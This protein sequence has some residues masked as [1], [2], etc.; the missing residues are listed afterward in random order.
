MWIY[1]VQT[2]EFL[3]TN[4]YKVGKTVCMKNRLNSYPVNTE[5]LLCLDFSHYP[6]AEREIIKIFR[7]TF[8]KPHCRR[9]YFCGDPYIM[10]MIICDLHAKTKIE[11]SIVH[12]MEWLKFLPHATIQKICKANKIKANN[13]DLIEKLVQHMNGSLAQE[14][15]CKSESDVKTTDLFEHTSINFRKALFKAFGIDPAKF[16]N[17]LAELDKHA[18]LRCHEY[19]LILP[20]TDI[21]NYCDKVGL[22]KLSVEEF[23]G[24]IK[25]FGYGFLK[26]FSLK[27]VQRITG[28]KL[29]KKAI[30]AGL[31]VEQ[32]TSEESESPNILDQIQ[33]EMLKYIQPVTK[34]DPLDIFKPLDPVPINTVETKKQDLIQF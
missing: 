13:K 6:V 11:S 32:K 33:P 16:N 22:K 15:Y 9:E 24:F 4:I 3:S 31:G 28:K 25:M 8:G 20:A 26:S 21:A 2:G 27:D 7:Q 30:L 1:L 29:S 34:P 18:Q 17:D 23:K 14:F 5:V 12:K 19:S 10:A